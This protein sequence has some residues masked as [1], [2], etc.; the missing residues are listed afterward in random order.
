MERAPII[1]AGQ[2]YLNI[3]LNHYCVITK[4][5]SG[6]IHFKGYGFAGINDIEVFL[7]LFNPVDPA[8]L[9]PEEAEHLLNLLD[10]PGVELSVGWVIPDG[11]DLE[12]LMDAE[13]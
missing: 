10:K 8:D 7:G 2:V 12:E 6:D 11:Q 3:E 13:Y 1:V 4:A 5:V 9:E